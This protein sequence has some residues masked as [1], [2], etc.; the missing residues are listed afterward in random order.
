MIILHVAFKKLL[1]IFTQN[2]LMSF[3]FKLWVLPY[4]KNSSKYRL[5]ITYFAK[6]LNV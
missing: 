1:K 3:Y 6:T 2:L 4:I 5:R